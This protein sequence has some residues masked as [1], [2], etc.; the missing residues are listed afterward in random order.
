MPNFITGLRRMPL[1]IVAISCSLT[2]IAMFLSTGRPLQADDPKR[3]QAE[4]RATASALERAFIENAD[5]VGP[6]TVSIQ[7]EV[8]SPRM[9]GHP[10][11]CGDAQGLQPF[12]LFGKPPPPGSRRPL[13]SNIS[14]RRP[15]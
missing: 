10:G 3:A 14:Q 8:A 15:Q 9:A 4:D 2:A 12:G 6:A 13:V 7:A 1:P 5:N 11:L